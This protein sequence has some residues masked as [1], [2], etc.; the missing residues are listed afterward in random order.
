[1]VPWNRATYVV[2]ERKFPAPARNEPRLSSS[3]CCAILA[4]GDW[5]S[6]GLLNKSFSTAKFIQHRMVGLLLM[7]SRK[8]VEGNSRG[9]F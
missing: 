6:P 9:L 1:V 5:T 3:L 2:A 7:I 8:D 4:V